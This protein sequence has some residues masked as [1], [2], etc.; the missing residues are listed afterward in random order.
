MVWEQIRSFFTS[1]KETSLTNTLLRGFCLMYL[2]WLGTAFVAIFMNG[3]NLILGPDHI[4][5][6][7]FSVIII[8]ELGSRFLLSFSKYFVLLL[9]YEG[10]R[11]Y[12]DNVNH[13][14]NYMLPLNFDRF[15]GGG[16]TPTEILQSSLK[17]LTPNLD[18]FC[19]FFY[20]LHFFAPF[21]FALLLWMK[22]KR[23][24][25]NYFAAL[26][27]TAYLGLL[28]FVVFPVAPPW[29]AANAGYISIEHIIINTGDNLGL[30][31]LPS[32][33]HLFNANPVAAFPSLHIAFPILL[34]YFALKAFGKRGAPFLAYPILMA[35]SLVYL[36]EHY[37]FDI[38]GG[39]FYAF[40]GI[41][42]S[43]KLINSYSHSPF[44]HILGEI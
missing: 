29:L 32:L 25:E 44:L 3:G 22:R 12:A 9:S 39:V 36:G 18:V 23:F 28:T 5:L 27:I 7:V 21:L 8:F 33:Y 2:F 35:F 6:L 38:L 13:Y 24:Y 42:V 41:F 40:A 19:V 14:V 15:I 10:M 37:I 43:G 20:Y 26:I 11:G 31:S 4:F 30:V 16:I 17:F 34:A 1:N